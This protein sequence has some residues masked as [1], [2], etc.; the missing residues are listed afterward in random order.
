MADSK[1]AAELAKLRDNAK[2]VAG[3]YEQQLNDKIIDAAVEGETYMKEHAPWRDDTG[4]RKDRSPGA[5][6]A[7]LF[8]V[9]DIEG[10][11]KEILFSHSVDY[12]IWLET[13]NS[14]KYEIIMPSVKHI[15]EQ[16]M[17]STEGSLT[18][19]S[20]MVRAMGVTKG[21]RGIIRSVEAEG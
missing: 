17:A 16:L 13:K 21:E 8:T 14:G 4:N 11:T 7:G 12:G 10:R 1:F 5:A 20:G 15:G 6:R 9:P 3:D 19:R 2:A 18:T